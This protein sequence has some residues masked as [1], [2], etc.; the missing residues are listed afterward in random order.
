MISRSGSCSSRMTVSEVWKG[1][2]LA[3]TTRGTATRE[4]AASTTCRPVIVSPVDS[5]SERG[6]SNSACAS[7]SVTF[8]VPDLR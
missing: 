6:P 5:R 8:G 2:P 3:A 1:T 7:Y 4:P